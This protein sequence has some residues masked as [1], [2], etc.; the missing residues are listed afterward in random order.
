VI[1]DGG[2]RRPALAAVRSLCRRRHAALGV[3]AVALFGAVEGLLVAAVGLG[4]ASL[5]GKHADSAAGLWLRELH[6]D[7]AERLSL[8]L[9]SGMCESSPLAGISATKAA[10]MRRSSAASVSASLVPVVRRA[11]SSKAPCRPWRSCPASVFPP[12]G[13]MPLQR[14]VQKVDRPWQQWLTHAATAAVASVATWAL[15]AYLWSP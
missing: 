9:N 5:A 4:L 7:P 6:F 15:A 8:S 14:L 11:S 13:A 3:R 10:S 2:P 12:T 1:R